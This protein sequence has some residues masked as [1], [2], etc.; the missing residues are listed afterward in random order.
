MI[1]AAASKIAYSTT[2]PSGKVVT[3]SIEIPQNCYSQGS[4][5]LI[6]LKITNKLDNAITFW[7][8]SFLVNH[9]IYLIDNNGVPVKLTEYYEHLLKEIE[10]SGDERIGKNY[11]TTLAS[12]DSCEYSAE[13]NISDLFKMRSGSYEVY[14]TYNDFQCKGF[15][16]KL[17]SNKEKIKVN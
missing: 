10:L 17:I 11:P 9:R 16:G 8:S 3:L 6:K 14:V 12:G 4:A 15:N 1:I 13:I 7:R 2:Y 5:M